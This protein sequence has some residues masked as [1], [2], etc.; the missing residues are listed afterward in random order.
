MAAA[1]AGYQAR[2]DELIGLNFPGMMMLVGRTLKDMG[3]FNGTDIQ[4]P[5]NGD[6]SEIVRDWL[7]DRLRI[8]PI[9]LIA[10][11]VPAALP[12]GPVLQR[13]WWRV[14][15]LPL[16]HKWHRSIRIDRDESH[17]FVKHRKALGRDELDDLL[18]HDIW[19]LWT[20]AIDDGDFLAAQ[21]IHDGNEDMA[22]NLARAFYCY[23]VTGSPKPPEADYVGRR[24]QLYLSKAHE[25]LE[26]HGLIEPFKVEIESLLGPELTFVRLDVSAEMASL[27]SLIDWKRSCA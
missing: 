15:G 18:A 10:A 17:V 1:L 16:I 2:F 8:T 23:S 27:K 3:T 11:N 9:E 26:T 22:K 20:T 6:A 7:S 21:A 4:W 14:H 12:V 19:P 25:L 13:E 5:K 24:F